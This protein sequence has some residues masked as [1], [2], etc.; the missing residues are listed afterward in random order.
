ME[1]KA[2]A[3]GEGDAEGCASGYVGEG[4]GI[5]VG[6][7]RGERVP[8]PL[9]VAPPVVEG[10][11]AALAEPPAAEAVDE[12]DRREEGEATGEGSPE[13]VAR[14]LPNPVEE[15]VATREGAP[16]REEETLALPAAIVGEGES[17]AAAEKVAPPAL[18]GVPAAEA[19]SEKE[20]PR[21]GAGVPVRLPV[22]APDG[23]GGGESEGS[24]GEGE[25]DGEGVSP[26]PAAETA[27]EAEGEAPPVGEAVTRGEGE[28]EVSLLA[29]P[30]GRAPLIVGLP[31][32]EAV[33]VGA[34]PLGVPPPL[35]RESDGA[36]LSEREKRGLPDGPAEA[37]GAEGVGRALPTG[38]R[39]AA[40]V[41][42][43]AS[44]SQAEAEGVEDGVAA[45][46]EGDALRGEADADGDPVAA[47]TVADP[48][49]S[50]AL[51]GGD[52]VPC[53]EIVGGTETDCEVEDVCGGVGGALKHEDGEPPPDGEA[54]TKGEAL[55]RPLPL[56]STET[57]GA[58]EALS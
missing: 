10:E 7:A 44:V 56:P 43:G 40:A 28:G 41:G 47:A 22:G 20:P 52:F 11:G 1:G 39:V 21:E 25:G 2:D 9:A 45:A 51:A 46:P 54:L 53:A 4:G 31:F 18:E 14:G 30:V 49:A 35:L 15:P 17:A 34:L 55:S 42:V 29:A 33:P 5:P 57:E 38:V 19:P 13:G 23:E 3:L 32:P 58:G 50:E 24:A 36:G 26:R 6:E 48:C 16:L 27:G 8:P 37:V 12:G